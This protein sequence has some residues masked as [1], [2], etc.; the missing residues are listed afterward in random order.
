MIRR[1]LLTAVLLLAPSCAQQGPPPGGPVDDTP[2]EV[3]FT[4]PAADSTGFRP[5]YVLAVAFSEKMDKRSVQRNLR[6]YPRPEW[7]RTEWEGTTLLIRTDHGAGERPDGGEIVTVTVSAKSMDRRDN[8]MAAPFSFSFTSADSLP[9]GVATGR[10]EG[11]RRGREVP[12]VILRALRPA[13]ADSL[14][15]TVITE[16]EAGNDGTFRIDHLPTTPGD[17]FLLAAFIDDDENLVLDRDREDYGFSDTLSFPP[18]GARIDSLVIPL[19]N[20]ETPAKLSGRI[21]LELSY[22]SV[23][24]EAIAEGDSAGPQYAEPDSTG[25][26]AFARLPAGEYRVRILLGTRQMAL[27]AEPES[28]LET[29]SERLLRLEPGE[30]R[31]S[32]LLP[33]REREAQVTQ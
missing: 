6:I 24:V 32:F 8:L 15:A 14:P 21:T 1:L 28:P 23:I 17:R 22:D 10:V 31:V 12:A 5:P 33:E 25:A 16:T 9:A 20:A 27:H 7:I 19:I 26:Y 13:A 3:I 29:L 18:E 11:I 30:E 4:M 2:P